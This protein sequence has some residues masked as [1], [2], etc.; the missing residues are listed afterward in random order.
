[1]QKS[2]LSMAFGFMFCAANAMAAG[3][4]QVLGEYGDWT[5]YYYQEGKNPVCYM[6]STPKKDEGR[7]TRRGDIYAVITHRPADKSFGV[8]NF[9]AGYEYKPNSNV[10]VN[11]GTVSSNKLFVDGDKAWAMTEAVDA[12]L[13]EAM[14]KYEKMIVHGTSSKGTKTKDTYSL[15]GFAKT[16]R[17][18]S[19]KCKK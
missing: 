11:I 16:Y 9:V 19:A 7:Y 17:T 3:D 10:T 18:I 5:A 8:I 13:I 6:V 14:K 4:P 12:Q 1:M 2:L 15:K